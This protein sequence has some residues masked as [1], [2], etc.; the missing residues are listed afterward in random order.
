MLAAVEAQVGVAGFVILKGL[1]K[2]RESTFLLLPRVKVTLRV[3]VPAAS[4]N[5][6]TYERPAFSPSSCGHAHPSQPPLGPT[7]VRLPGHSSPF[8]DFNEP[9]FLSSPWKVWKFMDLPQD[10]KGG[11]FQR[12]FQKLCTGA[13]P[14]RVDWFLQQ[15]TC[16]ANCSRP[17]HAHP[18]PRPQGHPAA[19]AGPGQETG[20][21]YLWPQ[22][23]GMVRNNVRLSLLFVFI[24]AFFNSTNFPWQHVPG[25]VNE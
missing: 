9:H 25:S 13:G 21:T 6:Q 15:W 3:P 7:Q 11:V 8:Q 17:L 22:H 18:D 2:F 19:G 12:W 24:H 4:C 5:S 1:V 14:G 23:T 10:G 20:C 16:V